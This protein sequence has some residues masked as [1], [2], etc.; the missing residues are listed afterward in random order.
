M[1]KY[2]PGSDQPFNGTR[3]QRFMDLDS[4]VRDKMDKVS[5]SPDF[6]EVV[7]KY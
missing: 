7:S 6:R 5:I 1:R 3:L 2:P 4:E